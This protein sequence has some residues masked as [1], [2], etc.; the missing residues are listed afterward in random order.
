MKKLLL[1]LLAVTLCAGLSFA[2][3]RERQREVEGT[4]HFPYIE[5][6][7]ANNTGAPGLFSVISQDPANANF[8]Y[9]L[10]IDPTGDLCMASYSTVSA[11]SSFPSGN[12]TPSSMGCNKVGTQS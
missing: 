12:W 5:A 7:G 11:Y 2:D 8:T 9:Y 1:F 6:T 4:T 10:W 3:G